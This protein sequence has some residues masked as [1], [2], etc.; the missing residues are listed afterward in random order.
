M[1]FLVIFDPSQKEVAIAWF[2]VFNLED[3][4]SLV[5]YQKP[6]LP[7]PLKNTVEGSRFFGLLGQFL[8]DTATGFL[9]FLKKGLKM[10]RQRG[11]FKV[12]LKKSKKD[13]RGNW[14]FL[15]RN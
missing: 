8:E 4:A 3:T 15:K 9:K 5:F 13:G 6:A 11:I 7:C 1:P 12:F 2:L 10:A 14:I